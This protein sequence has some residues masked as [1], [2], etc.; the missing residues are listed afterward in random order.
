VDNA[1]ET[2]GQTSPKTNPKA[3]RP[4][5]ST[6]APAK[7][8][9][10]KD[11]TQKTGSSS[12][13]TPEAPAPAK[14]ESQPQPVTESKKA[15]L[16]L[17]SSIRIFVTRKY[18]WV[19][20]S[21]TA[22][23]SVT[24]TSEQ[25]D[26]T[27][28]SISVDPLTDKSDSR[29][30]KADVEG[31]FD[32]KPFNAPDL[33]VA[34]GKS[35]PVQVLIANARE[36]GLAETKLV[37]RSPRLGSETTVKLEAVIRDHWFWAFLVVLLGTLFSYLA[38]DWESIRRPML[39]LKVEAER[40]EEAARLIQRQYP[41]R[42]QALEEVY[43]ALRDARHFIDLLDEA[44]AKQQ[45]DAAQNKLNQISGPAQVAPPS[46]P[47]MS[48]LGYRL[49]QSPLQNL[50]ALVAAPT[51]DLMIR[52]IRVY[53]QLLRL[54]AVLIVTLLGLQAVYQNQPFGGWDYIKAFIW[55]FGIDQT[56]KGF[57]PV[58]SKLRGR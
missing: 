10:Q 56:V 6:S 32:G 20:G 30:L 7:A 27:P 31:K 13:P 24:E 25:V 22:S 54:L 15:S 3:V 19:T 45:I 48:V 36:V 26:A 33:G 42:S 8:S 41:D 12:S 18:P 55:G 49:F 37:F 9:A 40:I 39:L 43:K 57:G 58:L 17:P 23:F 11:A 51:E 52:R 34:R 29:V 47:L 28:L 44:K 5:S 21:A 4:S 14:I 2:A 16:A 46:I 50:R 1:K 53:D 38:L 35:V